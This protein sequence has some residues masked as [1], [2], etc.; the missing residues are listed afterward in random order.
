MSIAGKLLACILLPCLRILAKNML[1]ENQCSNRSSRSTINMIFAF[2]Q[3][4]EK[5]VE[6]QSP[7]FMIFVDFQKAFDS[8]D[9][10]LFE[11]FG[12]LPLFVCLMAEFRT[13][14]KAAVSISGDD[15]KPFQV[16]QGVR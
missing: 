7:L 12:C 6:Q 4:Q 1:P 14:V 15:S 5:A 9:R 16:F 13:G 3:L 10:K 11:R 8:V 2:R